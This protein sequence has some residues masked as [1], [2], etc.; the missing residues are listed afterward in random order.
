M[1]HDGLAGKTYFPLEEWK[2]KD[3]M[4]WGTVI[5]LG[6]GYISAPAIEGKLWPVVEPATI[7]KVEEQRDGHTVFYGKSTK[8]IDCEFK[9]LDWFLKTEHGQVS[10]PVV[11]ADRAVIRKPGDFTF[12]PWISQLSAEELLYNSYAIAYHRCHPLWYRATKFYPG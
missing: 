5:L 11:F 7:T 6:W 10:A 8:L 2:V 12:G 1:A 4:K 3:Y 9:S